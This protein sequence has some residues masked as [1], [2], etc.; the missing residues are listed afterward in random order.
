MGRRAEPN[1]AAPVSDLE[2]LLD[3]RVRREAFTAVEAD[4]VARW[5]AFFDESRSRHD[6]DRGGWVAPPEM[7]TTFLRPPAPPAPG[8]PLATNVALHERLKEA[9]GLPV[10]IATGYELESHALVGAGDRLV[11]VERIAEVGPERDTRFGRGRDWVIEVVSSFTDG[12]RAGELVCV[13]RWRMTGYDP[14]RIAA[15][16]GEQKM[17][18]PSAESPEGSSMTSTVAVDRRFIV[19]GAAAN[20]VWAIA[21]HDDEAA[22]AAGLPGVI[23]DTSTWVALAARAASTWLGG[24]PRVGSVSLSMRRPVIAGDDVQVQGEVVADFVDGAD[25]R[26]ITVRVTALVRGRAAAVAD[27]RLAVA[28]A[29]GGSVWDLAPTRWHPGGS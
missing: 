22:V 27:V 14:A 21:H 19:D 18:D 6:T 29:D 1:G 26:R 12:A 11:S 23:V 4:T 20:R 17:S 28:S 3:E 7:V 10:G 9:L 8:E 5:C 16:A 15:A 2:A 24:D 25:V 13:E